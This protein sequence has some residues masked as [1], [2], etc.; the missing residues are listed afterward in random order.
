MQA[1]GDE[2]VPRAFRRGG[3]QDRRLEL[4][5]ALLDHAPAQTGDDLAAQHDGLVQLLAAKVEIAIGEP[6]L[7]R[8]VELAEHRQRQ[9]FGRAQHFELAHKDLDV[10]GWQVLVDRL[11]GAQLHFAVDANAPFGA[12]LLELGEGRAVLVGDDL[13]DAVMVPQIDEEHAPMIADP[14]R[15]AGEADCLADIRLGERA[16]GV[17][18]IGVHGGPRRVTAAP[19]CTAPG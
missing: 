11:V 16:A 5:E 12:H 8:V 18:S 4:G 13:G 10:A 14:V 15:P 3:R 7:F 6:R 17:A 9:L 2:K 19:P 1:R